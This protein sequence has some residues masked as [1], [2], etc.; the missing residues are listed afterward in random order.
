MGQHSRNLGSTLVWSYCPVCTGMCDDSHAHLATCF[1]ATSKEPHIEL[2]WVPPN[3]LQTGCLL[4]ILVLQVLKKPNLPPTRS[5]ESLAHCQSWNVRRLL[6]LPESMCID[7]YSVFQ[8]YKRAHASL[9]TWKLVTVTSVVLLSSR[10]TGSHR[11][12]TFVCKK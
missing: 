10:C 9:L 8:V 4:G 6:L 5:P 7:Y 2:L 11:V 12:N 1:L 3:C